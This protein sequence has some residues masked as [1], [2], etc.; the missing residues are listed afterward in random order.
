MSCSTQVPT[1]RN[2]NSD[3]QKEEAL[4]D[5]DGIR[6]IMRVAKEGDLT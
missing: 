2:S 6:K 5:E 1:V 3:F 4:E